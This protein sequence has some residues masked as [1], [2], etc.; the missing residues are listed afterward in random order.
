MNL[1]T[2]N[3]GFEHILRMIVLTI[4]SVSLVYG[5]MIVQSCL[6]SGL[7][8]IGV[9][10]ALLLPATSGTLGFHGIVIS[11]AIGFILVLVGTL[12]GC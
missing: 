3:A 9:G 12:I 5:L 7:I 8:F 2:D 6:G 11:G 10:L 1:R 4:A